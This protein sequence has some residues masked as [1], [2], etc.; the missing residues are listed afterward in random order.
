VKTPLTPT[1]RIIGVDPGESSAYVCID[2]QRPITKPGVVGLMLYRIEW[3]E[4]GLLAALKR[5][6]GISHVYVEDQYSGG[7]CRG[8][9]LITLSQRAGIC[10]GMFLANNPERVVFVTKPKTWYQAQNQAQGT[11]KSKM[12]GRLKRSLHPDDAPLV[13]SLPEETWPEILAAWGIAC[14]A[15][16]LPPKDLAKSR[17]L[18]GQM[19]HGISSTRMRSM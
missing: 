10:V 15:G 18:Y 8:E 3:V 2:L 19:L 16:K 14:C 12:L 6:D 5:D 17:R 11:P 4:V 13:L 9:G 7:K 1:P